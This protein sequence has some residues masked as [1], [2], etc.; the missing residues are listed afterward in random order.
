MVDENGDA[1]PLVELCLRE[2]LLFHELFFD[3]QQQCIKVVE[4]KRQPL[5]ETD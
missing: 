2:A 5:G 1:L 4:I 3:L